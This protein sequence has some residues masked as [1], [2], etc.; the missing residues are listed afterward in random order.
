MTGTTTVELLRYERDMASIGIILPISSLTFYKEAL[1]GEYLRQ[2]TVDIIQLNPWLTGRVV[3]KGKSTHLIH[4]TDPDQ[5]CMRDYFSTAQI[6]GLSPDTPPL[7]ASKLLGRILI[8]SACLDKDVRLFQVVL[9]NSSILLISLNHVIGDG[10]TYY[11]LYKMFSSKAVPYSL[12]TARIPIDDAVESLLGKKEANFPTSRPMALSMIWHYLVR[13]TK[14][15]VAIYDV[16]LALLSEAKLASTDPANNVGYVSTNDVLTSWFLKACGVSAGLMAVHFRDRINGVTEKSAGNYIQS[17]VLRPADFGTPAMIRRIVNNGLGHLG[18]S[19][20]PSVAE[21]L[22]GNMAAVTNWAGFYDDVLIGHGHDLRPV[23]HLPLLPPRNLFKNLVV[24]YRPNADR[25][26][27]LVVGNKQP[28][29]CP[30]F[31]K[32]RSLE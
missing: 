9:I 7:E 16:D 15:S 14:P 4:P 13:S 18:A 20:I 8:P 19:Q 30:A 5:A 12:T 32:I 26:A 3:T 6:T 24:I 17:V 10:Y 1:D 31:V 28:V 22:K 29:D 11:T 27:V 21:A 23:Y 25:L 2:R